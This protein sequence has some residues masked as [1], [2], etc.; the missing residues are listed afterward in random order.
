MERPNCSMTRMFCGDSGG[1]CTMRLMFMWSCPKAFFAKH[2]NT[3]ESL[4]LL[5]SIRSSDIMPSVRIC[6]RIAYRWL[7]SIEPKWLS[8][9]QVISMG[10]SPNDVH[11]SNACSPLIICR[12]LF[13]W[14]NCA[15][16]VN[17]RQYPYE[18][19]SNLD[20]EVLP[21]TF[22]K[23][24]LLIPEPMLFFAS[25]RYLP[26]LLFVTCRKYSEPLGNCWML[27]SPMKSLYTPGCSS[28]SNVGYNLL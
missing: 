17:Q 25:H 14:G 2:V 21:F 22:K 7:V 12:S 8:A 4:R 11:C 26:S 9:F 1:S 18:F 10:T 24:T 3:P 20:E 19:L 16:A 23:I 15:G 27:D 6:S 13:L 28:G 5:W